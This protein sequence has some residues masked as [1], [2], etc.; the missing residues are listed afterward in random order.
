[1]KKILLLSLAIG[2]ALQ[3]YYFFHLPEIVAHNFDRTGLAKAGLL[4]KDYILFSTLT[5]LASSI[6]YLLIDT[7]CRKI[8]DRFISFPYKE[9]WFQP[10]RKD[11]AFKKMVPW[12][13]F[14]GLL[15]NLFLISIFYL[16]YTANQFDP[17]LLNIRLFLSIITVFLIITAFWM[18]AL[19]IVFKP[20][21]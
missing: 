20:P 19:Y 5:I 1:M 16:L 6:I 9:Y 8:P 11:S 15:V 18:I 10:G 13:D 3:V 4:K 21:K 12:S 17:A 14:F 2:L 7:V